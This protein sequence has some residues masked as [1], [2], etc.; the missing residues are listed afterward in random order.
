MC[1]PDPTIS[2]RRVIAGLLEHP[3]GHL[4]VELAQ[5]ADVRD[6]DDQAPV[7]DVVAAEVLAVG[8]REHERDHRRLEQRGRDLRR[9][10]PAWPVGIQVD[11]REHQHGHEIGERDPRLD[12]VP[13]VVERELAAERELHAKRREQRADD[14]DEVE[15]QQRQH[16]GGAPQCLQPK[17]ERE[18]RRPLAPDVARLAT[19]S[20]AGC[21]SRRWR[22]PRG[23]LSARLSLAAQVGSFLPLPV[24]PAAHRSYEVGSPPR[25]I[26]ARR[27]PASRRPTARSC[28]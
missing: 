9:S 25:V 27:R 18:Q 2:A 24:T 28:G 4:E 7:E 16:P 23:P 15:R 13:H 5:R 26:N 19:R 12:P 6:R 20:E 8:E 3:A 17:D 10:G 22:S 14:A 11:P 21:R 1:L